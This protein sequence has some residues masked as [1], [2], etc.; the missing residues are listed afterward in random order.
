MNAIHGENVFMRSLATRGSPTSRC[1]ARWWTRC[2]HL[3]AA[4]FDLVLVETAGIGQSDSEIVDLVDHSLY[5]MTPEYGAPSQLEK[6]DML[7]FADLI[8]INKFDKQGS[9]EDALR[10]VR[11]QWRA[12]APAVRR[13]RRT[14]AGV[15]HHRPRVQRPGR[16]TGCT[17]RCA[18]RSSSAP[19][20]TCR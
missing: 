2:A 19:T 13:P 7:D 3:Q 15:R 14:A 20:R 16:R 12:T 4:D 5:V 18:T 8:A 11:K 9:L 1:R 10:D 17:A 6:I